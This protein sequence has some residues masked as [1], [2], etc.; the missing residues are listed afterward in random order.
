MFNVYDKD[1]TVITIPYLEYLNKKVCASE[2]VDYKTK[3]I[4]PND[5]GMVEVKYRMGRKMIPVEEVDLVDLHP[6]Y[7]LSSTTRRIPMV[8]YVDSVRVSMGTSICN[9]NVLLKIISKCWKVLR[10]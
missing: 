10:K 6:D 1:F 2:Y 5:Q 8:N 3:Q 7:R 9:F 4:K